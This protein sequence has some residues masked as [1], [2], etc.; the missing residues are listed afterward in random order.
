METSRNMQMMQHGISWSVLASSREY[1]WRPT[2]FG[3]FS[4]TSVWISAFSRVI[5]SL[6]FFISSL[7]ISW[8]SCSCIHQLKYHSECT[9]THHFQIQIQKN[10]WGGGTAPSP[11]GD[12]PSP[13]PTPLGAF[14]AS[15]LAPDSAPRFSAYGGETR[16][17]SETTLS[18]GYTDMLNWVY[19]CS[20]VISGYAFKVIWLRGPRTIMLLSILFLPC[21]YYIHVHS[22]CRGM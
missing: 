13:Y 21:G 5:V 11:G 20:D 6:S 18:T 1:T 12:T 10:L 8:L 15:I 17:F 14:G 7:F 16:H 4:S 9:K 2:E 22:W 3:E 19:H